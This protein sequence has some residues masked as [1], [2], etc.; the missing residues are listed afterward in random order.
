MSGVFT[1]TGA[2]AV[3]AACNGIHTQGNPSAPPNTSKPGTGTTMAHPTTYRKASWMEDAPRDTMTM[4]A[5]KSLAV[6]HRTMLWSL[7]RPQ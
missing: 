4:I 6:T 3:I 7:V 1:S 5:S 2:L